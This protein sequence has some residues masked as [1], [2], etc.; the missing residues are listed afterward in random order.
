MTTSDPAPWALLSGD[1]GTDVWRRMRE[2][3][4]SLGELAGERIARLLDEHT[5]V[6]GVCPLC[7][8]EPPC[9]GVRT[10]ADV[11]R[12]YDLRRATRAALELAEQIRARAEVL[13]VLRRHQLDRISKSTPTGRALELFGFELVY[14][15]GTIGILVS[16]HTAAEHQ[17]G[18]STREDR[19]A[20]VISRRAPY[21]HY[22]W[23]PLLASVVDELHRIN[24]LSAGAER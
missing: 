7:S 6:G 24:R 11:L 4:D 18:T 1:L 16:G 14:S 2:V 3:E 15:G 12:V 20:P 10:L 13:T 23:G 19:R 5:A 8:D 22:G 17:S 9:H 21:G